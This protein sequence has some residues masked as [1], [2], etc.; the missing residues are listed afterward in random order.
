MAC[1]A[2]DGCLARSLK[3][4]L[5]PAPHTCTLLPVLYARPSCST[6]H[7]AA[8][9]VRCATFGGGVGGR[10]M[11]AHVAVTCGDGV[12]CTRCGGADPSTRTLTSC[13]CAR[14]NTLS[15]TLPAIG[16]LSPFR[17]TYVR[18]TLQGANRQQNST[19][20]HGIEPVAAH[21][22]APVLPRTT[23]LARQPVLP[24]APAP[25]SLRSRMEPCCSGRLRQVAGPNDKKAAQRTHPLA[26]PGRA[27]R[28][29]RGLRLVTAQTCSR[30]RTCP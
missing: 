15:P 21:T 6:P 29:G 8:G 9:G 12:A 20:P 5:V 25:H 16:M 24:E 14:Y 23:A 4:D 18:L 13:R 19:A 26:T 3:I 1:R 11:Q 2:G 27:I 28:S 30:V 17:S 7:L 10:S 22:H